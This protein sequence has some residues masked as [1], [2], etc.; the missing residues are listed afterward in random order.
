MTLRSLAGKLVRTRDRLSASYTT[1][2]GQLYVQMDPE[3]HDV[4]QCSLR[5]VL[6]GIK[7]EMRS[8]GTADSITKM[9]RDRMRNAGMRCPALRGWR[10]RE[11][12][13]AGLKFGKFTAYGP[14]GGFQQ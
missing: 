5:R 13:L 14:R 7:K 8:S 3:L 6:A 1:C 2:A 4:S 9:Q 12:L 10:R 11:S